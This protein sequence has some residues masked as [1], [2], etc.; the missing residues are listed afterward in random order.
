MAG[1]MGKSEENILLEIFCLRGYFFFLRQSALPSMSFSGPLSGL[2]ACSFLLVLSKNTT[3]LMMIL[4]YPLL[5]GNLWGKVD[6]NASPQRWRAW[7]SESL[8]PQIR[9][10]KS[11]VK[12]FT[13]SPLVFLSLPVMSCICYCWRN[14]HQVFTLRGWWKE[15]EM[16]EI[17]ERR[18]VG[19]HLKVEV[20]VKS[21]TH[22]V[23]IQVWI[24][25]GCH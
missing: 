15:Q 21:N 1:M 4:R 22:C 17:R 14:P 6:K 18:E 16:I 23:S 8:I 2:M 13:A 11:N 3:I 24:L 20:W 12:F 10:P 5:I 7:Y 19:W 25:Y 9:W